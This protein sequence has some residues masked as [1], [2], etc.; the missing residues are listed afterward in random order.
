ML[1]PPRISP[2]ISHL[3]SICSAGGIGGGALAFALVGYLGYRFGS[4]SNR[5]SND[6]DSGAQAA[7]GGSSA[8]ANNGSADDGSLPTYAFI[9]SSEETMEQPLLDEESGQ[10]A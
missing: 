3:S 7:Y 9:S 8:G 6:E 1:A 5:Y 10:P 4:A 2:A